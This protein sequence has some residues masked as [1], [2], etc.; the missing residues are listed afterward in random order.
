ML[1]IHVLVGTGSV[2]LLPGAVCVFEEAQRYSFEG[3]TMALGGSFLW[4]F[5]QL[6]PPGQVGVISGQL[7]LHLGLYAAPK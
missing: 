7:G 2:L 4:W 3:I 6:R 5:G 1:D